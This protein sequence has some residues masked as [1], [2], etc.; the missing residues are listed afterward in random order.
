L[1]RRRCSSPSRRRRAPPSLLL[2]IQATSAAIACPSYPGA[3]ERDRI[4]SLSS[5]S[6]SSSTSTTVPRCEFS[7]FPPLP[8]CLG[9]VLIAVACRFIRC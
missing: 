6:I 8:D 5:T 4:T 3:S 9:F 7:L 1:P 2:P